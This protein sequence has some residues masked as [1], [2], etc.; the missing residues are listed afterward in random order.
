VLTFALLRVAEVE[1]PLVEQPDA[2]VQA[3]AMSR[4]WRVLLHPVA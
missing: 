4:E 2:V 1:E 3:Q